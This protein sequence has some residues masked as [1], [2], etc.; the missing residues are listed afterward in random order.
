VPHEAP[1]C[2]PLPTFFCFVA[3]STA[4]DT[5]QLARKTAAPASAPSRT[6]SV[7]VA[8][9]SQGAWRREMHE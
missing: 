4:S 9:S 8:A 6:R 7:R 1:L 2:G 5:M 3:F